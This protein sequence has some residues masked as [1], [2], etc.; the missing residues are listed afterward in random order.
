[1][2]NKKYLWQFVL[3][4]C[5]CLVISFCLSKIESRYLN[6]PHFWIPTL[7]FALTIWAF[8]IFLTKGNSQS[9][10]FVFKTL[11]LSIARLLVCLVLILIYSHI[12]SEGALAF[13]CHFMLQYAV[14]SAFEMSVLLKMI[15]K[16][17]V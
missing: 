8:H 9:K 6:T 17:S 13:A 5:C 10:E 16:K 12:N 14:F 3:V 2:D 11:A 1:M 7:F 15:R 4:C